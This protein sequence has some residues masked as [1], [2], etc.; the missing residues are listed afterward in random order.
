[1]KAT[2]TVRL[3]GTALHRSAWALAWLFCAAAIT[4]ATPAQAL[5]GAT[6]AAPGSFAHIGSVGGTSGVLV[7]PNWVLTAGH[8]GA[9]GATFASA[10]G[11]S[12]VA[13]KYTL[14]GHTTRHNDI[15]L[16]YLKDPLSSAVFPQINGVALDAS[17]AS[18]ALAVTLTSA[19]S[20][21]PGRPAHGLA[22]VVGVVDTLR[23]GD[24]TTTPHW[25]V[26]GDTDVRV[27]G[28]DSGGGLFLGAVSDSGH[29]VLLGVASVAITLDTG[30]VRSGY[31]QAAP[32]R[33]WI[34]SVISQ[35]TPGQAVLWTTTSPVPE[36]ATAGLW[37]AGLAML[38]LVRATRPGQ[39]P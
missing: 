33:A 37:L 3:G 9:V 20:A 6:V 18:E 36:A 17:A 34:D 38:V 12:E 32:Y 25:L 13:G 23:D 19:R 22:K 7:A 39:A 26:T 27:E 21:L 15:G 14:P 31:V 35:H 10:L 16:L 5:T 8:V 1:M 28:G 29:Q 4:C 11:S 30:V 2:T 24:T